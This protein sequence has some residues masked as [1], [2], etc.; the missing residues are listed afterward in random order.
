MNKLNKEAAITNVIIVIIMFLLVQAAYLKGERAGTEK[1]L[2]HVYP[3]SGIVTKIDQQKNCVIVTDATGNK[4]EF[5]GVEDWQEGD[6]AA[7]IM[8]DNNT[9]EIYDDKII[10]IHYIGWIEQSNLLYFRCITS[11]NNSLQISTNVLYYNHQREG[12]RNNDQGY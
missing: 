11:K 1:V 7:M 5:N 4:W 3:L 6:I 10:D 8:D 9:E 12:G 2:N